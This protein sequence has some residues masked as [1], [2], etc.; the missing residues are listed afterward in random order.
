M[1]PVGVG[2]KAGQIASLEL[3]AD[4]PML[5]SRSAQAE[6][7]AVL[8]IEGNTADFKRLELANIM[9]CRTSV[10]HMGLDLLSF[11]EE[12]HP[13]TRKKEEQENE[14][15]TFEGQEVEIAAVTEEE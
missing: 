13:W 15:L 3:E 10:G 6:L 12:G 5:L 7:G 4:V 2:G 1:W 14:Q 11:P 8:D 9:L